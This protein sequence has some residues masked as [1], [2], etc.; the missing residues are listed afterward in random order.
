MRVLRTIMH[1][2]LF[3]VWPWSIR[4]L[5]NVTVY[6]NYWNVSSEMTSRGTIQVRLKIAT[7]T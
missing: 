1:M 2:E 5:D 4:E 6:D 7:S 3:K